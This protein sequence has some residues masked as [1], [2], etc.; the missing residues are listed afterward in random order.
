MF[1]LHGTRH[2]GSIPIN[3]KKINIVS[4]GLLIGLSVFIMCGKDKGYEPPQPT[5]YPP[6]AKAGRDTTIILASCTSTGVA[7]LDGTASTDPENYFTLA[8]AWS[9]LSVPP[10]SHVTTMN[11]KT[12]LPT[13]SNLTT[14]KYE[15]ELTVVDQGG[16]SAKDTLIVNVIGSTEKEYDFDITITSPFQFTNNYEDCYYYWYPCYYY[17]LTYIDNARGTFLPLGTFSFYCYEQAD[18]ATASPTHATNF[19][20]YTVGNTF[21]VNGS[22]SVN[23]KQVFQNG[24]GPFNGTFTPVSGS[25]LGCDPNIFKSLTPLTVTGTMNATTKSITIN[26]KGKIYF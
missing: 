8:Y 1:T 3:M 23:F 7:R 20:L 17:D 14:G 24:G 25:A 4:I 13:F 11:L 2:F 10:N 19:G 16:L 22:S 18:T 5:N 12:S 9:I 15:I 21:S 6:V 26:I